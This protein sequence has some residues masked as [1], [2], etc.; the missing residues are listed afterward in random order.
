[1]LCCSPFFLPIWLILQWNYTITFWV[2]P[3]FP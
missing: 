3:L 1:V 2:H